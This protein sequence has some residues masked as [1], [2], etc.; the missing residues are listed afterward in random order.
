MTTVENPQDFRDLLASFAPEAAD[1][2]DVVVRQLEACVPWRE[3]SPD[4]TRN[5][6]SQLLEAALE[7]R[8]VADLTCHLPVPAWATREPDTFNREQDGTLRRYHDVDAVDVPATG[9]GSGSVAVV[10][11]GIE[12]VGQEPVFNVLVMSDGG[13]YL[14]PEEARTLAATLL[15]A[16]DKADALD[17]AQ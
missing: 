6:V 13:D 11:T 3:V 4:S 12:I 9:R 14:T 15:G 2:P 1:L 17:L 8:D 10:T 5:M 16:A 7:E